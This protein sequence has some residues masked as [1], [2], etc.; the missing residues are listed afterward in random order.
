MM[1]LSGLRSKTE[2]TAYYVG[3]LL[4]PLYQ[5]R[6]K[7]IP[8]FLFFAPMLPQ[9]RDVK[10]ILQPVLTQDKKV[11]ELSLTSTS[12]NKGKTVLKTGQ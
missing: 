9:G 10:R 5:K 3:L 6:E 12:R 8:S 2:L 1:Q 7:S 11:R 4:G